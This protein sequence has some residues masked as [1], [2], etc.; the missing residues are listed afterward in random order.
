MM[1]MG[2]RGLVQKM[3]QFLQFL[4]VSLKPL[5]L[6]ITADRLELP[7]VMPFPVALYL[8]RSHSL[9][10][11]FHFAAFPASDTNAISYCFLHTQ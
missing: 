6:R 7:V 5:Y 8:N 10:D 4:I 1:Y 2:D 3:S 9:I 11:S